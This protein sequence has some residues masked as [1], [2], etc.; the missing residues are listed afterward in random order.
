M[1]QQNV[2]KVM[3]FI[4]AYNRRDFDAAVE[5]LRQ[6]DRVGAPRTPALGLGAWPGRGLS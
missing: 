4:A 3:E 2:D 5:F 6:R 1:S